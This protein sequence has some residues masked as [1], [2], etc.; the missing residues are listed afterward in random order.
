MKFPS[1]GDVTLYPVKII[2]ANAKPVGHR[3]LAL[4]EVTGH[5]HEVLEAD[6][7]LYVCPNG[8]MYLSAPSGA[9]VQHD[10]HKTITPTFAPPGNKKVVIDQEYDYE[11]HMLRN[12]LD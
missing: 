2:P 5:K 4:G 7:T 8:D 3:V 9:T 10:E 12:V 1:Q 6:A 11:K